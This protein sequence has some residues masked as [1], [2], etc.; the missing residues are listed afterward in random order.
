MRFHT[1]DPV[2]RK[3]FAK[4]RLSCDELPSERSP[5]ESESVSI[6]RFQDAEAT[7]GEA[8]FPDSR[9]EAGRSTSWLLVGVEQPFD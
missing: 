1:G 5:E 9:P 3:L 7:L 4:E 8:E 6:F 2:R